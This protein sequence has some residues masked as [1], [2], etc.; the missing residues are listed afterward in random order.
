MA[1]DRPEGRVAYLSNTNTL[2][3]DGLRL[4]GSSSYLASATVTA[5]VKDS[6]GNAVAG[7]TFP[8]TLLYVSGSN[9]RYEAALDKALALVDGAAYTAEITVAAGGGVQ[10]FWNFPFSASV[11]RVI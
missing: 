10:G 4:L 6:A 8:V 1:T 11:R 3:L 2:R 9:G 7:E 5:T